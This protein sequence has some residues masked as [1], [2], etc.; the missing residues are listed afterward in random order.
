VCRE[1]SLELTK[2]KKKRVTTK[3]KNK[4][5]KNEPKSRETKLILSIQ[6]LG[7]A[8]RLQSQLLHAEV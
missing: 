2:K 8:N 1:V 3:K 5:G 4:I 6:P 7:Q